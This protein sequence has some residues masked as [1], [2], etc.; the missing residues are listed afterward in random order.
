M[1]TNEPS[2]SNLYLVR[3]KANSLRDVAGTRAKLRYPTRLGLNRKTEK[4]DEILS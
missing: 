3:L 4:I 2:Y 1:K